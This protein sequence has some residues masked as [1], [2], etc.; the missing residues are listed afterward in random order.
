MELRTE[1]NVEALIDRFTEM[2][3]R[4]A[5]LTGKYITQEDLLVQIL[6]VIASEAIQR[7]ELK[8]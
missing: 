2:A 3:R 1:V 7:V 5:L 6:G 4:G 8:F